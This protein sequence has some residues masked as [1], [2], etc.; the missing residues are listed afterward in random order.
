MHIKFFITDTGELHADMEGSSLDEEAFRWLSAKGIDL[1]RKS[2]FNVAKESRVFTSLLDAEYWV[3]FGNPLD[4][5]PEKNLLAM[6]PEL[7]PIGEHY[8]ECAR[9][10]Q[11][12]TE[13]AAMERLADLLRVE[14]DHSYL[15]QIGIWY[16]STWHKR[17]AMMAFRRSIELRPEAATY[18]NLAVCY[19]D[20]GEHDEAYKAMKGFYALVPSRDEMRQA[21]KMLRGNDRHIGLCIY[22]YFIGETERYKEDFL[23]EEYG[24]D[25]K[26][27]ELVDN[28]LEEALLRGVEEIAFE[29]L[30]GSKARCRFEKDGALL[31]QRRLDNYPSIL[32]RIKFIFGLDMVEHRLPQRWEPYILRIRN[33]EIYRKALTSTN[34]GEYGESARI[35]FSE[36]KI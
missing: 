28:M 34:P 4:T 25:L 2:S 26:V 12:T 32:N 30:V 31:E 11:E 22:I 14:T 17:L 3:R 5:R 1:R 13:T 36:W 16:W 15:R 33:H 19:D 10:A 8:R 29:C 20:L 21:E 18:F 23:N 27:I 6:G 9:V 7:G 35:V 24:Q